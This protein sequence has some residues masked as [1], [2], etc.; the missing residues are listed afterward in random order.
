MYPEPISA[1]WKMFSLLKR[2]QF[3]WN[4]GTKNGVGAGDERLLDVQKAVDVRYTQSA[5]IQGFP[6]HRCGG[7]LSAPQPQAGSAGISLVLVGPHGRVLLG[8]WSRP[9]GSVWCAALLLAP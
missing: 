5:E 1:T 4:S 8:S 3:H 9:S 2:G 7:W 6:V